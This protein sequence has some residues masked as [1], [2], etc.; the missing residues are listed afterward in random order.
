MCWR[1]GTHRY[2]HGVPSVVVREPRRLGRDG[3][4]VA[5][6]RVRKGVCGPACALSLPP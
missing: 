5:R 2:R 1:H 3:T 6:L 4:R